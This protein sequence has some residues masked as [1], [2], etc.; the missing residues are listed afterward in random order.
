MASIVRGTIP[1]EEFALYDAS[2]S[3]ENVEY[4]VERVVESAEGV[5]M[6]LVW[7][8]GSDTEAITD[9]FATDSSVRDLSLLAEFDDELLY[10]MEW[11]E[12][13]AVVIQMLTNSEATIMDAYGKDGWWTLRVLYPI[14]EAV[15]K[16]VEFCREEGLTFDIEMIREMEGEPAGRYGLTDNQYEALRVAS[17]LGYFKVPRE[18]DM[19]EL[20][21]ELDISHQ[22]LSE[23]L[24]RAYDTLVEDAVL[25]GSDRDDSER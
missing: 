7:I 23:R 1:A 10:R 21:E 5:V 3:L 6:P 2:S 17:E 13:V 9:A 19:N 20:A 4:E 8:R 22:A 11:T 16:T 12:D 25:V 18:I 14:R 15:S 24:R